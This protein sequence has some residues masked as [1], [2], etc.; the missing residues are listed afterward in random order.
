[1]SKKSYYNHI[2]YDDGLAYWF[3]ALSFSHFVLGEELSKKIEGMLDTPD[4]IR[5]NSPSFYDKL[6]D[7]G[8]LIPEDYDE[9]AVIRRRNDDAINRKFYKLTIIPT[10]NCN[11]KCWYC[12][13][14]HIPSIM[15]EETIERIKRH[16][17]YMIDV[18]GIEGL[19]ID[20]FGG[21]PFMFYDRVVKPLSLYA[22]ELCS[23]KKIPFTNGS[24]TNGYFINADVAKD[25]EELDLYYFQITLDGN[26]DFH[27][28]VKFQKGCESTFNHVLDNINHMMT[29]CDRI[30]L[31]LRINYTHDNLTK[32]IV[33]EISERLSPEIRNRISILPRKVWQKDIDKRYATEL[34]EILDIFE[35]RGFN[36]ERWSPIRN[37]IPCYANKKY[38][39]SINYNGHVLKCTAS[40]DLYRKEPLGYLEEDGSIHWNGNAGSAYQCK[41]FKNERCLTCKILPV[42]MGQCPRNHLADITKCAYDMT[43]ETFETALLT[44]LKHDYKTAKI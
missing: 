13:Q 41:A 38:Y 19:H 44:F 35:E 12:I 7:S 10:L 28:K 5:E 31:T 33:D 39:N 25:L 1:M 16:I 32:D 29:I 9:L 27:D 3:N 11:Y 22:K 8:F 14:D 4:V 21:E 18:E 2:L 34:Y 43:D 40:D 36:V 37:Y 23:Q 24:T 17:E 6:V 42:C 26:K 30:Q 20:W 15:S